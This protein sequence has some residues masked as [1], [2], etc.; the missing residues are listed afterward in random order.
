[1]TKESYFFL[2]DPVDATEHPNDFVKEWSEQHPEAHA[3]FKRALA[4]V[5]LSPTKVRRR[6]HPDLQG[7]RLEPPNPPSQINRIPPFPIHPTP[8]HPPTLPSLPISLFPSDVP[9]GGSSKAWEHLCK[10]LAP[11]TL[12]SELQK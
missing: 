8:M 11:N 12:Q 10:T 6:V 9:P 2:V 4:R 5:N 1:M 3:K 7:T